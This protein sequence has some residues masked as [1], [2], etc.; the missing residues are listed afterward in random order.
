MMKLRIIF[1]AI[2]V[3]LLC[4]SAQATDY[5]RRYPNDVAMAVVTPGNIGS[6][7]SDPLSYHL[8]GLNTTGIFYLDTNKYLKKIDT[9]T[10]G[11]YVN[12]ILIQDWSVT[13]VAPP[14]GS[15]YGF[16]CLIY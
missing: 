4:G 8:T 12:D 10:V 2:L 11:L 9:N 1:S 15:Y 16:G 14:A 6:Y 3:V 5:A 7:E 13:A